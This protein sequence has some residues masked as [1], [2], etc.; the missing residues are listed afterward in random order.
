MTKN[1]SKDENSK[2]TSKL[3]THWRGAAGSAVLILQLGLRSDVHETTVNVPH[4][5]V[6]VF[7]AA[8]V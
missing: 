1:T 8:L 2:G 3:A 4:K 6:P 7:M 5:A